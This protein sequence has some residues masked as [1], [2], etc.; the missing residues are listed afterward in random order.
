MLGRG[1]ALE[2]PQGNQEEPGDWQ[3]Q[4][5]LWTLGHGEAQRSRR[6]PLRSTEKWQPEG[7]M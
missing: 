2:G 7:Y 3:H 4:D 5:R 6:N 1:V